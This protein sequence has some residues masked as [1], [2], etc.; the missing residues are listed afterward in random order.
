MLDDH[1]ILLLM[2]KNLLI[3]YKCISE[4]YFGEAR[5]VIVEST[6]RRLYQSKYRVYKVKTLG[7][8]EERDHWIRLCQKAS[9]HLPSCGV[10]FFKKIETR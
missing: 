2:R 9:E 4:E 5:R 6:I 7:S 10:R 1:R 8:T 3:T